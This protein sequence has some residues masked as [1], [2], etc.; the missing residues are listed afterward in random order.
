MPEVKTYG[1]KSIK[2]GEAAEDGTMPTPLTALF[3]TYRDSVSFVEDDADVQDEYS[4][5][6]DAPVISIGTK[7]KKT[8]KVSTFDYSPEVLTAMKGGTTLNGQWVEPVGFQ[9][10]HKAVEITTDT[11]LPFQCSKVQIFTKF[12]AEFKKKGLAL[13]EIT[14]VPQVPIKIGKKTGP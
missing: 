11:D 10:I 13:L 4:D 1:L 9:T 7:G 14:M 5:Q 6:D 12:N 2:F 3:R 8:I